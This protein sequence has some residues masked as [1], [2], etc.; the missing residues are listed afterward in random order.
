MYDRSKKVSYVFGELALPCKYCRKLVHIMNSMMS[1]H[2][3]VYFIEM[4]YINYVVIM[5]YSVVSSTIVSESSD[6][7]EVVLPIWFLR[8]H[9]IKTTQIT[10]K[11]GTIINVT[12]AINVT[13]DSRLFKLSITFGRWGIYYT[14]HTT[15]NVFFQKYSLKQRQP[16]IWRRLSVG[17]DRILNSLY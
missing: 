4:Y 1:Y 13:C 6:L 14:C 15:E 2:D 9:R 8:V 12:D 11:T 5:S 10:N 3:H 7:L 17:E 16:S